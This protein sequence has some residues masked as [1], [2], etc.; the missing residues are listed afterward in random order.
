VCIAADHAALALVIV[1]SVAVPVLML[2]F[3]RQY[4]SQRARQRLQASLREGEVEFAH[5]LSN[6]HVVK[7]P[8]LDGDLFHVF[9]SHVFLSAQE[10]VMPR[11]RASMQPSAM[12]ATPPAWALRRWRGGSA[13]PHT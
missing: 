12:R 6:G 1:L 7:V 11:P 3:I 13:S 9:L 10:C 4:F 5:W 8:V 2:A